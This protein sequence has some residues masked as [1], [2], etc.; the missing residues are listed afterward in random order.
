MPEAAQVRP[1]TLSNLDCGTVRVWVIKV[2]SQILDESGNDHAQKGA[3]L[4]ARVRD[5]G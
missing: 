1:E 4:T 5:R 2:S 3:V